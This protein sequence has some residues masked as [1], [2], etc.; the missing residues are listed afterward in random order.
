TLEALPREQIPAAL[1]VRFEIGSAA[2][3]REIFVDESG[4]LVVD[5][6]SGAAS[7]P[8]IWLHEIAHVH[9]RGEARIGP[10]WAKRLR[11]AIE[12]GFADFSAASVV[13]DGR[14]GASLG[15]E[16][17]DLAM[18]PTIRATDWAV[19]PLPAAP[20]DEHRFGHVLAHLAL[21]AHG[22]DVELARSA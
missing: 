4:V 19:L 17:R 16:V 11:L 15:R 3:G 1:H 21:A 14:V 22:Y 5:A 12:E 18:S 9:A 7:D 8:T 20:F 10:T 13:K 2:R 6:S